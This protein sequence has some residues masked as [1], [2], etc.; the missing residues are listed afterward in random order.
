MKRVNKTTTAMIRAGL[1][2][3]TPLTLVACPGQTGELGEVGDT[4]GD[5]AS[6]Q[7]LETETSTSTDGTGGT[8]SSGTTS[9]QTSTGSEETATGVEG[10]DVCAELGES[11]CCKEDPDRDGVPFESDN[12]D[13]VYNPGQLD[14]DSDG[15]GDA[16]DLCPSIAGDPNNTIDSDRDGIGNACDRC[17]RPVGNYEFPESG[18]FYMRVRNVPTNADFDGDGIGDACDN[19][20]AMPNCGSW[21]ESNPHSIGEPTE[22]IDDCQVD[23]NMD[24]IGDS[25]E[26]QQLAG[27]AGPVG[28]GDDD[29]FDQDGLP[30][31]A[32][33]C[34]RLPLEVELRQACAGPDECGAN[35]TCS[36]SGFCDHVD[37]D[38]DGIGD[39][40]DTCAFAANPGQTLAGA[41]E[42]DDEDGDFIGA[43]CELS[44]ACTERRDAAPIGF[45]PVA[46]DGQCC[47]RRLAEAEDVA[48]GDLVLTQS[49]SDPDAGFTTENCER[50]LAA[51]PVDA[52]AVPVRLACESDDCV[53]LPAS[54]QAVPGYTTLPAGC[55]AALPNAG[56]TELEHE[57]Q[58]LD[59][60]DPD[61]RW[62]LACKLPPRDE[63]F[64]GVGD[65]CDKCQW[66]HDP[67]DTPY[68][69][70]N[71]MLWPNDGA[72][73]NGEFLCI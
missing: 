71:G 28:L 63:D 67:T 35:R 48:G 52:R 42:E 70:D 22:R 51:S 43:A 9:E 50:L 73:C 61:A 18:A 6:G 4:D 7:N 60:T 21:D 56:L 54:L 47:V 34:P 66:S 33:G 2:L 23:A 5:S 10:E 39:A 41:A 69:D 15:W 40:C 45:Y 8:S 38:A 13:D 24:G 17:A 53:Q 46:A 11:L 14:T 27:A 12:A 68:T 25:C 29:D 72:F 36:P 26:G 64:D 20:V 30:N 59:L 3:C 1:L 44:P 55:D 32:D 57:T 49:C 31:S 58:A 19:C 65:S 16:I 37:R 62:D